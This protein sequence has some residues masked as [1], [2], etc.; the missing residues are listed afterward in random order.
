M[1]S[2]ACRTLIASQKETPRIWKAKAFEQAVAMAETEAEAKTAAMRMNR[3]K[4][5]MLE[6]VHA[7]L[8]V[9]TQV[10]RLATVR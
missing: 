8:Q 6:L 2:I 1:T 4:S 10:L 9:Q 5:L 3:M 7:S